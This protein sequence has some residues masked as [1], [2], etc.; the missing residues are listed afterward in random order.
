[1]NEHSEF[2]ARLK[3]RIAQFQKTEVEN[4]SIAQAAKDI[5]IPET[6]LRST[7]QGRC[8]RSED[9]WMKL[10][11]YT[12]YSLDWLICGLGE[13]PTETDP[14]T[15]PER[16]LV[17]EK[18]RHRL[19]LIKMALKGLHIDSAL[20]PAEAALMIHE[21]SYDLILS[22]PDISWP[23]GLLSLLRRRRTRPR[24]IL[25]TQPGRENE[26]PLA[27]LADQTFFEPLVADKIST[28][29]MDHL[30]SLGCLPV[31]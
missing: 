28:M 18:D 25:L 21:N 10:R 23:E 8:P 11:I 6:T 4:I 16:I 27:A 31:T 7:L 30:S 15:Q 1:M 14:E 26:H 19:S 13:A 17:V 29:V 24:V 3:S 2:V 20:S 22:G 12:K 9:Y 5:G